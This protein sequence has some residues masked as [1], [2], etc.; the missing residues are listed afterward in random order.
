MVSVVLAG[1]SRVIGLAGGFGCGVKSLRTNQNSLLVY[2][3]MVASKPTP[4]RDIL[5]QFQL[6]TFNQQPL[7]T[8]ATNIRGMLASHIPTSGFWRGNLTRVT[9]AANTGGMLA[10]DS[11]RTS[12]G[13]VMV[14]ELCENI[15]GVGSSDSPK[16]QCIRL[17]E[18]V[19]HCD[20]ELHVSGT[21]AAINGEPQ[22]E[23]T[24]AGNVNRDILKQFQLS[25]FNQR[26]MVT[27]AT[28]IRGVTPLIDH[29]CCYKCGDSLD[30]FFCHQCT[31]EFCGS[32]AHD[33]C[34]CPSQVPFIQTLPSFPQQYP[35]CEDCGGPH[36][37][38]QCQ[39]MNY[40]ESNPCYDSNYSGFDQIEPPQYSINS[41]LN[42]QN[43]P[44]NH[45]LFINSLRIED[46]RLDTIPT[47]KSD[48]FIKSSVENLVP[49]PSDS[50]DLP[51]SECDDTSCDDFTNFSNLLFDANDDFSFSDD[52][53]ASLNAE[54]NLIE[55]LLN[56][57]S[58]IISSSSKI[59]SLLDEV[60]G[61]L[62]LLKTI[63]LGIDKT[64]CDPEEE[65]RLIEKL[66]YDNSSPR[67]SK[68][69]ISEIFDV[70]IESFTPSP[71]NIEDNDSPMEEIDLSFTSDDSMPPGIEEDDYDSERDMLI[72]E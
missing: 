44:D 60:A 64:D 24:S 37:T 23:L 16:R 15:R 70:A 8:D 45:E 3:M 54:S 68:E 14:C 1:C 4:E 46:E 38:F 50:E 19:S 39:P 11:P 12:Q 71:I 6:S 65:I 69:F 20:P 31:C 36:K 21:A 28:N 26:P 30:D 57:D 7:V 53:S 61:E 47:M 35:C 2:L 17:S 40:F 63:P 51:D 18:S 43:K 48:E 13:N 59:D 27:D 25:T 58:S 42:I 62:I 41:S 22:L 10:S 33:G 67:P 34:N 66:L 52:E 5:K 29:H 9:V 72:F 56:H 32:D 49:N 55:S